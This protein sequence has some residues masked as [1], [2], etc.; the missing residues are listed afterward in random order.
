M[1]ELHLK[2]EDWPRAS[3]H[4]KRGAEL[5]PLCPTILFRLSACLVHEKEFVQAHTYYE[6][7]V[8]LLPV[9]ERDPHLA[10]LKRLR[11]QSIDQQ[12]AVFKEDPFD[13]FPL[14]VIIRILE[15]GCADGDPDFVLKMSWTNRRWRAVLTQN[16]PELWKTLTFSHTG[17]AKKVW[18]AKSAAWVKRAGGRIDTLV[19][20]DISATACSRVTRKQGQYLADARILMVEVREPALLSRLADTLSILKRAT[21]HLHIGRN[22]CARARTYRGGSETFSEISCGLLPD[23]T[24]HQRIQ[25]IN[26][27]YV[28]FESRRS[29][30]LYEMGM[31]VVRKVAPEV[32]DY[33]MLKTLVLVH[34]GFNNAAYVSHQTSTG[35]T[36]STKVTVKYQTDPLHTALRG[37]PNLEYLEV[38]YRPSHQGKAYMPGQGKR[39]TMPALKSAI[40]PSPS[41]VWCV[42]ITAPN[43]ESLAFNSAGFD[44]YRFEHA[45]PID[46]PT[47]IPRLIPSIDASPCEMDG[48][49]TIKAFEIACYSGDTVADFQPWASRLDNVTSLIIR[50]AGNAFPRDVPTA[51]NPDTR[52]SSQAVQALT[53]N[54]GNWLPK[55]I[56]LEF[57]AC[58]TPGKALVE[59]VR[60][61][62]QTSGC[63]PLKR[64]TLARCGKLSEKAK[65]ALETEVPEFVIKEESVAAPQTMARYVDDDFVF[66]V[67]EDDV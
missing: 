15:L 51:A 39:I 54:I 22:P 35:S 59:Y 61:R 8:S 67:D 56:E 16:C 12:N 40:L 25:S 50:N 47:A 48:L 55:L 28:N 53:D 11:E 37:S 23:V 43:L 65:R 6:R 18:D 31:Y 7:A 66:E 24:S 64:L 58:L 14:E 49:L 60:K 38:K 62:K 21:E 29:R 45:H 9:S 46:P 33:S 19:F 52:L 4:A 26:V 57:E 41:A 17:F 42:D 36:A 27:G 13:I 5:A 63:L 10:K 30:G 44:K 34:C 20:D 2:N 1:T 3:E 32:R